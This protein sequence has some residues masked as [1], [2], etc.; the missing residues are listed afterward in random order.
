[1]VYQEGTVIKHVCHN[2]NNSEMTIYRFDSTAVW[3]RC[4]KCSAVDD[5]TEDELGDGEDIVYPVTEENFIITEDESEEIY[6]VKNE[7]SSK[8]LGNIDSIIKN[9]LDLDYKNVEATTSVAYKRTKEKIDFLTKVQAATADMGK[10]PYDD[11][12]TFK[13]ISDATEKVVN[14]VGVQQIK[15]LTDKL[16]EKYSIKE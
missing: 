4:E 1:M 10:A 3:C 8:I 2:C 13:A 16:K 9:G 14:L 12:K 15:E 5:F 6:Q 11:Q 7:I